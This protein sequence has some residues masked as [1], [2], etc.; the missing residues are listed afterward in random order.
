MAAVVALAAAHQFVLLFLIVAIEEAGIPLPAPNDLV[1]AYYGD[2]ARDDMS[3][4]AIVVVLCAAASVVGTL[5]PFALARRFGTVGAR[6]AAEW[7]DISPEQVE[8]WLDRIAKHGFA[9]VFLG[10]LIPGSR[11]VMSFVA[12]AVLMPP[13][14][15][16][17]AV[18]MSGLVYWSFWVGVG[19]LFGQTFRDVVGPAYLHYVLIAL[20]LLFGGYLL[21][22]HLRGR[23][24]RAR[25]IAAAV[26]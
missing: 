15:F 24:R 7:V 13:L 9:T 2:R 26:P 19:V 14:Q 25:R 10:R 1:V 22:R 8:R 17:V 11:V 20:P 4:L 3:Q 16:S 6:R 21:F 23:R 18:F 5:P 12:G